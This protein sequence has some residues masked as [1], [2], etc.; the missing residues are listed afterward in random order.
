MRTYSRLK[1]VLANGL[2]WHFLVSICLLV[3][4]LNVHSKLQNLGHQVTYL[5]LTTRLLKGKQNT[6]A[7][8]KHSIKNCVIFQHYLVTCLK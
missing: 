6:N 4:N 5:V 2:T 8:L 3:M 7:R 1:S